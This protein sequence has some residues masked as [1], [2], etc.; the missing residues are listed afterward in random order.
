MILCLGFDILFQMDIDCPTNITQTL[1]GLIDDKLWTRIHMAK[2][3]V[4]F[5]ETL[6]FTY[7]SHKQY[8]TSVTKDRVVIVPLGCKTAVH[9]LMLRHIRLFLNAPFMSHHQQVTMSADLR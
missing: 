2:S 8:D 1:S 3:N 6:A 5:P 9:D 4:L 7:L